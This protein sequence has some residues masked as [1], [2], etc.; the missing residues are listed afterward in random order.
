MRT[1]VPGPALLLVPPTIVIGIPAA[2]PIAGIGAAE[3]AHRL[4]MVTIGVGLAVAVTLVPWLLL[5]HGPERRALTAANLAIRAASESVGTSGFDAARNAAW[6]AVTDAH[7]A[8]ALAERVPGRDPD[9]ARR[10]C[11]MAH[12]ATQ[13]LYQAELR[14][15]VPKAPKPPGAPTHMRDGLSSRTAVEHQPTAHNSHHGSPPGSP[16]YSDAAGPPR[17]RRRVRMWAMAGSDRHVHVQRLMLL[18]LI[19][20]LTT[21]V[22]GLDHWYWTPVCAVATLWGSDTVRTWHRAAQRGLA[23]VVGCFV[24]L[25]LLQTHLSFPAMAVVVSALFFL[26]EL[27]FPRNYGL[28]MLFVTPMVLLVIQGASPVQLNGT[29]L[30]TDRITTTLL[31]C[32]FGVAGVLV[33]LPG[34]STR[35]LAG[36]TATS[37]RLQGRLLAEIAATPSGEGAER[38]R[39]QLRA[40]LEALD[41]LTRD[42]L[43][44]ASRQ[45]Q[46]REQSVIATSVQRLGHVMLAIFA[47]RDLSRLTA[48]TAQEW[49]RA[50]EELADFLDS[51]R[52]ATRGTLRRELAEWSHPALRQ[53]LD[54]LQEL[55]HSH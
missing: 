50:L 38:V 23:T 34:P 7:R 35:R 14:A 55:I 49:R 11:A 13:Q 9:V 46:A 51:D 54:A 27:S 25:G 26:G 32:A 5:R 37:L 31:G 45:R 40:D 41:S 44:E 33:L 48:A 42:A 29:E 36:R 43:G 39:A 12:R 18:T 52:P 17:P 6:L 10:L 20:G 15:L 16:R 24:G 1:P 4:G 47:L 19:S 8:L 30:A 21:I 53:Q 2:D 22:I 3:V 28:A